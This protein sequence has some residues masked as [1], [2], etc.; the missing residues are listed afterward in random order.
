MTEPEREILAFIKLNQPIAKGT[1]RDYFP[2]WDIESILR[3]LESAVLRETHP[4]AHGQHDFYSIR[5]DSESATG[6]E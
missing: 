5:S 2:Q 1:I 6:R 3:R 4:T